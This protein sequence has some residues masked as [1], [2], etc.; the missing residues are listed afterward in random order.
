M[1]ILSS[2]FDYVVDGLVEDAYTN[3]LWGVGLSLMLIAVIGTAYHFHLKD[4][5]ALKE[6]RLSEALFTAR[7]KRYAK[8]LRIATP[9][10]LYSV[11]LM[12]S[13]VLTYYSHDDMNFTLYFGDALLTLV[14][15]AVSY[16]M[17][18]FA[19][20]VFVYVDVYDPMSVG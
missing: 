9:V 10:F 8:V 20:L 18:M 17:V 5:C 19:V 15:F 13:S 14:T 2:I 4:C 11:F 6:H 12:I 1:E 16:A 7:K 3:G